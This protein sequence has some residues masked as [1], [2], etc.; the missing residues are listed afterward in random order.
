MPITPK[1]RWEQT[2]GSVQ[3]YLALPGLVKNNPVVE[4]TGVLFKTTAAPYLSVLDLY[5][6]VDPAA[7]N[8]KLGAGSVTIIAPKVCAHYF[9]ARCFLHHRRR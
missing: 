9:R 7:T 3:V 6:E 4:V 8:V 2:E 1:C 5:D